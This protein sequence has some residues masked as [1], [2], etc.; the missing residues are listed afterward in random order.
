MSL[1]AINEFDDQGSPTM[2]CT[3]TAVTPPALLLRKRSW[4]KK[5]KHTLPAAL[6]AQAGSQIEVLVVARIV[7]RMMTFYPKRNGTSSDDKKSNQDS[8]PWLLGR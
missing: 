1:S 5:E 2:F 3:S 6:D 8:D 4:S 7:K